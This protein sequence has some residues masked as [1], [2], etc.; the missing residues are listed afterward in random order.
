MINDLV[1]EN[2]RLW[3]YV[4]D[5]TIYETVA[6]EELRNAQRTT[7]RVVQWSLENRVQLNTDKCKEMQIS[8]TKSQ[9]KFELILI[10]G[11]ALEVVD[12]VKLLGLTIFSDLNWDIHINKI[13]KAYKRLYFL[14]QLK[15]AK[16]T[17][18]DLG[19][20]YSGCI[21][22][23]INYAVPAFQF[24]LPKYLMQELE[25][26]QMRAMSIICPGVSYHKGSCYHELLGISN[27]P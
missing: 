4:D 11:D 1:V 14:V 18:T 9:Q 10:N 17:R 3:T 13:L 22:S 7:D 8:F 25:R 16:V 12:I 2:A 5:N 24:I 26:I 19:L 20:F 27:P 15:R 23:I 21:R 6:K